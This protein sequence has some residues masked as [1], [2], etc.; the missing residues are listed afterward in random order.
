MGL[1]TTGICSVVKSVNTGCGIIMRTGEVTL[2]SLTFKV[3][4]PH[5]QRTQ[6]GGKHHWRS[7]RSPTCID[8][9]EGIHIFT[10]I[11]NRRNGWTFSD[12]QYCNAFPSLCARLDQNCVVVGWVL[13]QE[14]GLQFPKR[15]EIA[16]AFSYTGLGCLFLYNGSVSI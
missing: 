5:S 8:L 6:S 4:I 13:A 3:I 1:D 7:S 10:Y 14:N 11:G 2:M 12:T 16:P 9:P 15:W